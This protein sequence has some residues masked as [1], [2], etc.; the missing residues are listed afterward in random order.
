MPNKNKKLALIIL[1]GFGLSPAIDGN[2]IYR[3]KTPNLDRIISQYPYIALRSHGSE[4]GLDWGVMGNSEVG[5]THIGA[6]RVI[7]QESSKIS[8][9]I[10]SRNFFSN[11]ILLDAVSYAKQNNKAF[12]CFGLVSPG[13]IH[14]HIDHYIAL[15]KF[16]REQKVSNIVL[17][18]IADGRDTEPKSFSRFF[19]SLNY[20][21]KKA[22]AKYATLMGRYYAMDRDNRWDRTG[23]AF[24]AMVDRKGASAKTIDEAVAN[25]YARNE[26]DEFI[27]PTVIDPTNSD[28]AIKQG[29]VLIFTNYRSDRARQISQSFAGKEFSGFKRD[30]LA[31]KYIT[32]SNYGIELQNHQIVFPEEV[33]KNTLSEVI[34]S[35]NLRQIHIAETEKYAHVTHFFNGGQEQEFPL[36]NR[37]L[38]PSKKVATY[39]EA[40]AMSAPEIAEAFLAEYQKDSFDVAV[41]N[42]ANGDMV[43]HTGDL[44]KA[45]E[46]VE[47]LD[48]VIGKIVKQVEQAGDIAIITADHGNI[49]QLI[50]PDTGDIDKEH[51]VNPV[52]MILIGRDFKNKNNA[53]SEDIKMEFMSTQDIGILADIAPTVIDILGLTQPTE[54]IGKSLLPVLKE[55]SNT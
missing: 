31:L 21:A 7:F 44:K 46:G 26:S 37:I 54:M 25:A 19:S 18:L 53:K 33:L 35:A 42:F 24:S 38:I 6:G 29:D 43:G 20:Y 13:G 41:I 1:D 49:E 8:A 2:A 32:F 9:D 45:I 48:D 34:S 5:H 22:K 50:H 47:V 28:L 10:K 36:E 52:P 11:P 14:G 30:S 51:T 40:P 55:R 3:A 27:K 23:A 12:H 16:L 17:H 39:D 4:V 15:L